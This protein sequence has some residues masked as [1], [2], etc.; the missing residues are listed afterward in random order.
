MQLRQSEK[1]SCPHHL[2]EELGKGGEAAGTLYY[3]ETKHLSSAG[4]KTDVI[5]SGELMGKAWTLIRKEIGT[6]KNAE[7]VVWRKWMG[8]CGRGGAVMITERHKDA[9]DED[10]G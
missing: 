10:R 9:R 1:E 7:R 5:E 6:K 8:C 3:A 2:T 4:V